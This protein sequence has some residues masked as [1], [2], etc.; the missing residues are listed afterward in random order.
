[1]AK[2]VFL[3]FSFSAERG[4]LNDLLQFF[5]SNGGPVEATP[6]FMKQDLSAFGEERIKAAVREQ[7]TGC[8]AL[9]IL[10]GDEA[11]NSRWIQYE[12][13][14]ANELRIPKFGIRHPSHHGGFPNAHRGMTEIEWN[15]EELAR[16]VADL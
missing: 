11:H 10:I 6:T 5:H 12:A 2:R 4:L 1:M 16:V 14:V 8:A 15:R 7:M 3:S 13:G 9:L